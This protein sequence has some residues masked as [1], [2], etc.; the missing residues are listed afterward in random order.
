MRL[1]S[2]FLALALVCAF[3]PLL[4]AADKTTDASTAA[5]SIAGTVVKVSG[6]KLT[7]TVTSRKGKTRERSVKVDDKTK[8]TL[9]GAEAKLSDL[10]K[11]QQVTVKVDHR[12]ATEIVA[13]SAHT[14]GAGA[15]GTGDSA[16][17]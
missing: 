10:K 3:S 16:A 9:D 7:L 8:I 6:H 5:K 17:K 12:L 1:L 4:Q 11:D 13:T 14:S 2:A 15:A